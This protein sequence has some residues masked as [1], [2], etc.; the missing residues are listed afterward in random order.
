MMSPSPSCLQSKEHNANRVRYTEDNLER[1][2]Q[3][4]PW[5]VAGRGECMTMN[6]TSE[7]RDFYPW[8][9]KEENEERKLCP[10]FHGKDNF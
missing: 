10:V 9:F 2:Q 6:S 3:D 4:T 5:S 1:K 8:C 7:F